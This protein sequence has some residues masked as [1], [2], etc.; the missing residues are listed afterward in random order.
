MGKIQDLIQKIQQL[1]S[2]DI[3][4][5]W[6]KVS[7]GEISVRKDGKRYRKVAE[8]G[9]PD[10][11]WELVS[12]SEAGGK[13]DEF[14]GDKSTKSEEVN[15]PSF[16]EKE[17][18]E[19][20]KNASETSLN[21]AIKESTDPKVRQAAHK[22][23]D[24]REEEEKVQEE[25][26]DSSSKTNI[27]SEDKIIDLK[28]NLKGEFKKVVEELM[29]FTDFTDSVKYNQL[30]NRQKDISRFVQLINESSSD[31]I[32][33]NSDIIK[34]NLGIK[35]EVKDLI[36]DGDLL[37]LKVKEGKNKLNFVAVFEDGYTE[38]SFNKENKEVSMDHFYLNPL[39]EKGSGVGSKIFKKQV[40]NFKNLGFE[41]LKTKAGDVGGMNGYYTWARLGYEFDNDMETN[42]LLDMIEF[43]EDEDLKGVKS[44]N[45]LMSTEKGINWWR[46][47]GFAFNGEF[48]LKDG[49]N[50]MSILNNYK[51]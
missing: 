36:G 49:S 16:T 27:G 37:S 7:I 1:E 46:E 8:T 25:N 43:E 38:R 44:L 40:E 35:Y 17:L 24:R 21:S 6:K 13:R 41:K 19:H 28:N 30:V 10:K 15:K 51:K 32:D 26:T 11:D 31:D 4:K 14:K 22:E 34:K 18:A 12:D 3:E 39:K 42:L 9:N 5:A 50:S 20:A 48:N 33:K 29:S 45:D 23:L 47:N 2:N